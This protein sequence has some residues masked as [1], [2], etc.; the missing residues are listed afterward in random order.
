MTLKKHGQ[1]IK[2]PVTWAQNITELLIALGI[3]G[4]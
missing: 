3:K 4:K 1:N 2:D